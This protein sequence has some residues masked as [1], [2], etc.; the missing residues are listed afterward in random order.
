MRATWTVVIV[1]RRDTVPSSV[2][3]PLV[4]ESDDAT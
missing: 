2:W 4:N 3:R 1:F